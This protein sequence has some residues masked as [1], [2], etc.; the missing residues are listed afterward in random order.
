MVLGIRKRA[1]IIIRRK[2]C[3]GSLDLFANVPGSESNPARRIGT[4]KASSGNIGIPPPPIIS[5]PMIPR[6]R[7]NEA[8]Q[9]S[10]KRTC[11]IPKLIW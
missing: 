9:G 6:A 4:Y 1:D 3:D 2:A 5:I 10:D 8:S 11:L 7:S